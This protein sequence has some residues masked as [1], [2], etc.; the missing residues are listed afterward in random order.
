MLVSSERKAMCITTV[1]THIHTL[2]ARMGKR[3]K[4]ALAFSHYFSHCELCFTNY[5]FFC[6]FIPWLYV[7]DLEK[8]WVPRQVV[9]I[10]NV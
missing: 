1:H 4:E 8:T 9:Y 6:D 10:Y 7:E 2:G 5:P 3:G